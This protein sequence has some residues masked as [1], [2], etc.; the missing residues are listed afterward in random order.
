[1]YGILSNYSPSQFAQSNRRITSY[2]SDIVYIYYYVSKTII[3]FSFL[4]LFAHRARL[5]YFHLCLFLGAAGPLLNSSG[6]SK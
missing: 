3:L 2:V 5:P 4:R 6:A 1:M